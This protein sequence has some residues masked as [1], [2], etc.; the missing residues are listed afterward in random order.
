[1]VESGN[2]IPRIAVAL[3]TVIAALR[4]SLVDRRVAIPY[5]TDSELRR[6]TSASV[7]PALVV[8]VVLAVQEAW[9]VLAALA[10]AEAL[11]VPEALAVPV[12]LVALVVPEVPVDQVAL[13]VPEVSAV[14]VIAAGLVVPEVSAVLE[15][16]V[17]PAIEGAPMVIE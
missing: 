17:V 13:V 6:E 3:H 2:T 1:V 5:R 11:V 4:I 9:V 7:A 12:D 10:V 8:A 15:A 16:S 14:L